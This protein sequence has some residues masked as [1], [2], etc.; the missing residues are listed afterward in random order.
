MAQTVERPD[1]AKLSQLVDDNGWVTRI[2]D[3]E[4]VTKNYGYDDLG[5]LELID[6]PSGWN[7]ISLSFVSATST[8]QA[9]LG[10]E[11][12]T[13]KR[14]M[15]Q[16][17]FLR[18]RYF[19]GLLRPVLESKKDTSSGITYH[20][21]REFDAHGNVAFESYWS[22]SPTE[23]Q[24]VRNAYDGL[25][26]LASTVRTA[27]SAENK[28][29]YLTGNRVKATD[30]R[31]HATTVS[32]KAYGQPDQSMP[33]S[34]AAPEGVTTTLSYNLFGNLESVS[35]GGFTEQRYYD[36]HQN[37]CRVVRPEFGDTVFHHTPAGELTWEA[38]GLSLSGTGCQ[39]AAVSEAQKIHY[40][41]DDL[42]RL[43]QTLYPDNTPDLTFNYTKN[44]QLELLDTG[45]G[46]N[47]T[48]GYNKLGLL[49]A[50]MLEIDSQT[51]TVGYGY[52][53]NGVLKSVQYPSSRLVSFNPDAF[54][55]PRQAGSYANS[56]SYHPNDMLRKFNYGNGLVH[57]TELNNIKLPR[58]RKNV[59]GSNTVYSQSA[60]Y[61]KSLNIAGLTDG[62]DSHYNLGMTYD[63]LD[64]LDTASG[65][66]GAGDIDYDLL[67]NIERMTLGT[68]L[69]DYAYDAKNR[70][71]TVT[72]SKSYSFGY[73]G[74]GNVTANGSRVFTYNLANQMTVSGSNSYQYDGHG[75]R[76]KSTT[77]T[78]TVYSYYNRDGRLLYK[79]NTNGTASDFIYLGEQLVAKDTTGPDA[80]A[81]KNSP[82][83]TVPN[84]AGLN[85][86]ITVSWTTVT[87]A[88]FYLLQRQ[89]PSGHWESVY[90]QDETSADVANVEHNNNNYRVA[91]CNAAGCGQFSSVAVSIA[92]PPVPSSINV[93]SNT[94]TDGSY[95]ISWNSAV[96]ATSYVLQEQKGGGSWSQ[97]ASQSG[98]SKALNGRGN[99]SYK[100]RVQACNISGC[101]NW[102]TSGSFSVLHP[103][104]VPGAISVPTGTDTNGAYTVS[105]ASISTATSYTLREQKNGGSYTTVATQSGTSKVLSGRGNGTYKYAVRACNASGCSGYR[106]STTFDVL[107]PPTA[108]SLS[109]PYG[110]GDGAYTV[111]WGS[112][113][114]ATSYNLQ[115]K[116]GSGSWA[117]A[118]SGS[119]RSKAYSG[120]A[121]GNYYYRVRACNASGCGS[122]SG[123]K[124]VT[125]DY[126]KITYLDVRPSVLTN[127][128]PVEVF[129]H[130][131]NA[132][133]CQ[134]FRN[135]VQV[136]GNQPTA[137]SYPVSFSSHGTVKVK[138]INGPRSDSWSDDITVRNSGGP[139]EFPT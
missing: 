98:T 105:W 17:N 106:Y 76:V 11:A 91:A 122:W 102:K 7:D 51:F 12:G 57:T 63:G 34:I 30:P 139:W 70:L 101:S 44:G 33:V 112:S 131:T 103:P 72:G 73:D 53:A 95:T 92:P 84:Q 2:T 32:Y 78:G 128:G 82:A 119:S 110:D 22:T 49:D 125:V 48:Y 99:G 117:N 41:Y 114:T 115:Q 60:Y 24:G 66:W 47:W 77:A 74:R 133:Y 14:T 10:L 120:K 80:F 16:G 116:V 75:K 138:C 28:I 69:L 29:E 109:A 93:P 37:L 18:T 108:P 96:G 9:S 52:N 94:N 107:L 6:N 89:R 39:H 87:D 88:T 36:S 90:N 121:E 111:S 130:S 19:D 3:F 38:R 54:G 46:A 8:E 129:W 56:A 13:Y 136:G 83:L 20:L 132:S 65:P 40:K 43:R 97:V 27:D 68:S 127:P 58:Q 85:K 23:S 104:G 126:P 134:V 59:N 15:S 123:T 81:P 42:G 1:G 79:Y 71:D 5:R 31:G 86:V 55:R 135:G 61:D 124:A 4:N 45:N 35:Q 26:R 62:I 67:G 113:S 21:N 25:Q 64:R 118:Y 100:Y 137:G 50:E